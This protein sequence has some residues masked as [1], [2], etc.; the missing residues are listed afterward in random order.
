MEN[1]I[2]L[3]ETLFEKTEGYVKSSSELFK[4]KI[5]HKSADVVSTFAAGFAIIV[6]ITLFFL[7]LNIGVALW[8]GEMMGNSYKGFFI[9][10]GFYALGGIILYLFRNVWIKEPLKDAIIIQGLK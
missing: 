1:E 9:V 7:I 3:V 2:S 4:L 6:F 5:I 10:S 8:V